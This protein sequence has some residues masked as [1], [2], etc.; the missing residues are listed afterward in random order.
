MLS[1]PSVKTAAVSSTTAIPRRSAIHAVFVSLP[2]PALLEVSAERALVALR[3]GLAAPVFAG[4]D[5]QRVKFIEFRNVPG[6][7]RSNCQR[8]SSYFAFGSPSHDAQHA[9]RIGIN[10]EH[11][12]LPRIEQN[13]I[14][15]FRPDAEN[16][17]QLFAQHECRRSRTSASASLDIPWRRN[18][19][20][21]FSVRAF[22]RQ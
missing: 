17:D 11:A 9:L 16:S 7:R 14:G 2:S 6:N 15:G 4:G 10:N 12:V 8:I 21:D 5:D 13:R 1:E 20:N 3:V 22:C 19:T 18:R